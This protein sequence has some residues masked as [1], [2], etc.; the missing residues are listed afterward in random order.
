MRT[1]SLSPWFRQSLAREY[2]PDALRLM[3]P[4]SAVLVGLT[5]RHHVF[6]TAGVSLGTLRVEATAR[7]APDALRKALEKLEV[8]RVEVID[9]LTGGPA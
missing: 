2:D 7:T 5:D 6:H 9:V 3:E 1:S 4:R 8:A